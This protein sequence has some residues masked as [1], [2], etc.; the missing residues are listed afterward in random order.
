MWFRRDLRVHDHPALRT[1][2]NGGEPVIPAF[3]F[4]KRLLSGRH[5]SGPRTQFMLAAETGGAS[6]HFS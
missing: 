1:A 6:V 2:V 3:C 5:S 4:D